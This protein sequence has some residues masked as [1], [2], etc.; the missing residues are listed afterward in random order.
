MSR[1][2]ELMQKAGRVR[3]FPPIPAEQPAVE[4][5]EVGKR[6]PGKILDFGH[7]AR[8][9]SLRLV[10]RTFLLQIPDPPRAVVFAG[11]DHGNGCS[12]LCAQTAETLA[13]HT[14]GSICLVDANLRSPSLPGLF[15]TT[16]H[17]GL[18]DALRQTGSIKSFVRPLGVRNISLLS[19]GSIGTDAPSLLTSDNLKSRFAELRNEF[20]YV[21]VDAPPLSRYAD[22]ITLGQVTDGF[23][24][25]LEANAT[26][27]EVAHMAAESLHA[28]HIRI[29]GAVLTK[30]TFPIPA[31]LYRKL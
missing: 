16:N 29:L 21:L 22:A 25:V 19:C 28:A 7:F 8:E 11:I 3:E 18:T 9:E 23:V 26:R 12:Q 14:T 13:S 4:E 6:Q 30:R 2:F 10:Q 5:R 1:N 17:Y 24:L 20:D 27:R 15:H 31:V